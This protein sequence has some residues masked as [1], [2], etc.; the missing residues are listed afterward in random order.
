MTMDAR[1]SLIGDLERAIASG[2]L[3]RRVASLWHITDL[4]ITGASRY[5]D[6]QISLFDDVITRLAAQIEVTARAKLARLLAPVANAPVNTIKALASDAEIEVAGPV[7]ARSERLDEATLR[8]SA[9]RHS[10]LH[11]LAISKRRILSEAVTDVLIERGDARVARAVTRN[12]G[13]R[14]SDSGFE[15]LVK[16]SAGDDV[17][18]E[19]LGLRS[20]IPR[21]HFLRLI[22]R[23]SDTVRTKLAAANPGAA[24]EIDSIVTEVVGKIHADAVSQSDDYA[25]ARR[26]LEASQRAGA[27]SE[28]TIYE[29][30]KTRRFE[31]T[32]VALALMSGVPIE[33][34]ET[35]MLDEAPDT[36]LI[37]AKAARLSW[38]TVK[39]VLL[40][41]AGGHGVSARELEDALKSYEQLSEESAQLAVGFYQR[42][43]RL[44]QQSA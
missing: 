38:T 10:Q 37:L 7:L 41:R 5:S 30:A 42:R 23:A 4:F 15:M 2:T 13:A 8:E 18:A 11:L 14:F 1:G 31:E 29:S 12:A 17:L 20:D 26:K 33:A 3:E 43:R 27:L 40:L 36:T 28:S 34:A 9:V 39:F 19:R 25:A 44:A 21:H 16:R 32:V 24:E 22:A 6:E 35:A